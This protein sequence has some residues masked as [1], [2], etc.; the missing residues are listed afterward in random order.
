MMVRETELCVLIVRRLAQIVSLDA[1]RIDIEE[2]FDRHGL[3]SRGAI[4]LLEELEQSV[5]RSL[6]PVLI[7]RYPTPLAL[8]RHLAGGQTATQGDLSQFR[9]VFDEPIAIVGM[10][11]R[12]PYAPDLDHY[13]K[14][15][16]D[17]IDA[18]TEIPSDR[19]NADAY[20]TP[21]QGG[22]IKNVDRF[23]AGFFGISPREAAQ[24]DPQQRL[25]LELSWEALENAGLSPAL[26]R[27]SRTAVFVGAM[28][29]DYAK[30]STAADYSQHSA[31]GQDLSIIAARIS[32][33]LGLR[34]PSITLNSA[35]SSSLAAV[36]LARQSLILG[37]STLAIAGGVS[38]ML[39]PDATIAMSRFGALAPDG[40]CKAFDARADGYG[41]GEGAG[42]V[43][44]KRL[45][46]AL[47]DGDH[48]YCTIR[49]SALNNDGFSNGLSAPSPEAQEAVLRDAYASAGVDP[50]D[51]QY[52][53]THGTGTKLGDPI[54]AAALSAVLCADRPAERPLLLG[55]VKTN[56]G[57]LE[58][59]AG[60]A[61]LIKSALALENG[62][63]PPSLHFEI[64][65]P[66]IPFDGLRLKVVTALERIAERAEKPIVGVSSFGF[67]GTNCHVVLQASG[68]P[69]THFLPLAAPNSEML[70]QLATRVRDVCRDEA[71]A[72]SI[73]E[74][75]AHASRHTHQGNHRL[76]ITARTRSELAARIDD[77]LR[78]G[79]GRHPHVTFGEARSGI[80]GPVFLFGGQGSQWL[81]MGAD[82]LDEPAFRRAI[83]HCDHAMRPYL[84]R[85]LIDA[86]CSND[87]QWI[88]NTA[89]VQP[90]VV[91]VQIGLAAL[92]QAWGV[93]PSAVAGQSIGEVSAAV[94]AGCLSIEDAAGVICTWSRLVARTSGQGLMA[95]VELPLTEAQEVVARHAGKI[96]IGGELSP[97]STV[98]SG[99]AATLDKFMA[100]VEHEGVFARRI[101]IDYA[102]HSPQ[103]EPLL[104]ELFGA[105]ENIEPRM[106]SIPFYS[107]VT[108]ERFQGPLDAR[109][110]GQ[111]LRQPMQFAKA[112][113]SLVAAH[114]EIFV[115]VSPH[116]VV[117]L[118][119]TQCLADAG[120]SGIAVSSLR[121]SA[122]SRDA[123]LD[124]LR[125]LFAHGQDLNFAAVHSTSLPLV[126]AF[127]EIWSTSDTDEPLPAASSSKTPTPLVVSGKT[128]PAL[129]AQAARLRQ[130]LANHP[131]LDLGDV[132]Y[133]SATTRFPFDHRAVI[134]AADRDHAMNALIALEQGNPSPDIIEGHNRHHLHKLVFV[135]PG[136]G[137][138]WEGMARALFLSSP[139][140]RAH[141]D[142]CALALAPHV[143]FSLVDVILGVPG[144]ASL[145]RVG[146]VQP[147][148]FA[149]MVSL[150]AL[151]QSLGIVP[152][153]VVGHS[154]GE[155]AAAHVAG[156]LSLED[157]CQVIA[158][159]SQ[160]LA[161]LDGHGAMASVELPADV[162]AQ[163]IA[164]FGAKLAIAARNSPRS[165]VIAGNIDAVD[166]VV[167]E[168]AKEN[169][170]ARKIRVGYA[171]HCA[172]VESIRE[173]LLISLGKIAPQS[174]RIPFHSTV[175]GQLID[176]SELDAQY[177]YQNLR[178][179]V[180]FADVIQSLMT[181]GHLGF[182][183][184]S[185]HPVLSLPIEH[186]A[187]AGGHSVTVVGS[188]QRDE[189]ELV[190]I[191]RSLGELFTQGFSIDWGKALPPGRRIPLPAY[192]FQRERHWVPQKTP[193][194]VD[195]R[196]LGIES[197]NHPLFGAAISLAAD[198]AFVLTGCLAKH[199]HPWLL[200]HVVFDQVLLG[201]TAF[202][203]LALSAAQQV[204]LSRIED[205]TVEAPLALPTEG[206]VQL[207]IRIGSPD[208]TARRPILFF[209]RME[210]SAMNAPW[211]RHAQG[212]LTKSISNA[213]FQ[214]REWP[215]NQAQSVD[216]SEVYPR[217]AR[218]GLPY[219]ACFRG[220]RAAWRRDDEW[221]VE[222][223]LPESFVAESSEFGLHPALFDAVLHVLEID[224][225]DEHGR[226]GLPFSW[227]G[228]SL[229][230]TGAN[231]LRARLLRHPD[232]S[233][234]L[235]LADVAGEPVL[236]VDALRMR[237]ASKSIVRNASAALSD[238]L[239]RVQW[240]AA[241]RR[242]GFHVSRSYA[243]I[244]SLFQTIPAQASA[245][246]A[247]VKR[248]A[249]FAQFD[250]AVRSGETTPEVLIL[251]PD[252]SSADVI[253]SAHQS[254]HYI[255]SA[256]QTFVTDPLFV[257]AKLVLL[258]RRAVATRVEEDV[259]ALSHA[260]LWGLL[261]TA[262]SE[263]PDRAILALDIDDHDESWAALFQSIDSG[264]QQAALREGMLHV[265]RLTRPAEADALSIPAHA[266]AWRMEIPVKGSF[267]E[268][269]LVANPDVLAPLAPG[270]VRVEMRAAGLNFRDVLDSLGMLPR[271]VGPLGAE[272]AGIVTEVGSG[273]SNCV[274]GDRVMGLFLGAFGP[275]AV[276]DHRWLI[277]MPANFSFLRAASIPI[278][279]LTA[280]YGLIDL[281]RLQA[282]E[283]VLIHAAAG[284]VG[285]AAVQIARHFGAEVFGTA[286]PRK[287][288][289]LHAMGLNEAHVAS[290]RTIEFEKQFLEFTAGEGMDLVLD[291]LSREFI[292]A[293]LRLLPRGGRFI[294]MGK[295]D[296]RDPE[297]IA[298]TYPGVT[299]RVF[300][301][302]DVDPD[303][304]QHM[305]AELVALFERGALHPIPITSY[306]IRRAPEAFRFVAQARHTGKVVFTLPRTL[307]CNG[308]VLMTGGTGKLG[309]L[310]AEHLVSKYGIRHLL[311]ASRQ[312]PNAPHAEAL[313][314]K[315]ENIGARVTIAACDIADGAALQKLLASISPEH[316]LTGVVHTAGLLDDGVL[317]ALTPDRI[318]HVFSPKVDAAW[319]LH[320]QTQ[321][322][323]LPL[324]I[325]F[326][327]LSG[328]L[329]SAGQSN[330]AAANT[331]LDA[332]AFHR[333]AR[334]LA[335][336]SLSWGFWSE[337]SG[338][339]EHLGQADRARLARSGMGALS[340][341]E[342]ISLFD[343]AMNGVEPCFVPARL[344][345]PTSGK[346]GSPLLHDFVRS[347]SIR[348]ATKGIVALEQARPA[349]GRGLSVADQERV[350]AE[351]IRAEIA[352]VLGHAYAETIDAH[353]PL[354][355]LGLDSLMAVELRNRL[356]A[357]TGLRLPST[358][359]FDH[360]TPDA[361]L[362]RIGGE[363]FGRNDEPIS[364]KPMTQATIEDPIAIVAMSCRYPG[365]V[366]S[367]EDLWKLL[368]N[369][370]DAISDFPKNRG[371]NVESLYDPDP[372]VPHKTYV[373]QGG[374][375]HDADH[376]D[377]AF[378][379]I[380]PREALA[381]DPQQ[382][383]LLELSWE[384]LERAGID[385]PTLNGSSTGVFAGV[386]YND[387]G[388]RRTHAPE[389][390]EGYLGIGS[391]GSVASGRIAYTFG[392]EGPA[393]T[394]DTACSSSLVAIHLACQALRRGECSLALAGGVTVLATPTILFEF[395]RQRA[396]SPEGRS[397]AFSAAAN[398]F[399][400]AEGAGILLLAR[401]NDAQRSGYPIVGVIRGSAVNQDGKS[402]GLTAPN[403][404]AQ[405]RVVRQALDNA[406]LSPRDIGAVE[407]HGTGTELGDPIEAQA[408]MAVY[409]KGRSADEP[410]WLGSLKSNIGHAQAAAG[411][412]GI[413]KMALA[414]H[415]GILPKTL[416]ADV[417][418]RHIDWAAGQVR[419][420]NEAIPW[421]R[422]GRPRR[423]GISSF[424]ISGTNAHVILEEPPAL[425][426]RVSPETNI[427]TPLPFFLS[428]KS[429]S[430]LCSWARRLADFIVA[431]PEYSLG[432]I[433]YSLA[434]TRT[435]F[436][437]RAAIVSSNR[438]T[439]LRALDVLAQ[440][441]EASD[442]VRNDGRKKGRLVFVF[443]GQGG[444]WP[445]MARVLL[446]STPEFRMQI[447]AC[448][449]ALAPHVSFSLLDV[450]RQEKGAASLDRVDVVQP[451]L[452]AVM[453]S[454][455]AVW[456]SFGIVPDAVVG[457]SQGEIAAAYVAGGLSLE[458]ACKI[459]ALRS[460]AL[461]QLDGHGA[462]ASVELAVD[463]LEA[464]I[465]A[466]GDKLAIASLNG[467][468]SSV[469]S[470]DI[471]AVDALIAELSAG[472]I[473]AKKIRVG[474][475]SH[476]PQVEAIHTQ[477]LT[478]LADISSLKCT[479]PFYSTVTAELCEDSPFD[480]AYWY[481][482]LRQTV[483]FCET[484]QSLLANDFRFFLEISP[485]PVLS[486]A[487][488]ETAA[489][490]G[491]ES[492]IV[493]SLRR[494]EGNF[495]RL[496]L[497]FAELFIH[498]L[499][500]DLAKVLPSA[501]RVPLPT[502]PFQRSRY[503]L[504]P[505]KESLTRPEVALDSLR[506]RI[507]WQPFLGPRDADISGSWL[508]FHSGNPDE[509]T[510]AV[511]RTL[512]EQKATIEFV[513]LDE[514]DLERPHLCSRL[515]SLLNGRSWRGILSLLA[516][517]ETPL[518]RFASLPRGL[519][520]TLTL[521]QVLDD[522]GSNLPSWLFTRG[523]VSIGR[524]DVLR[525][526]AQAMVWG[527]GRVF[528]LERPKSWGG[529]LD[530]PDKLDAVDASRLAIALTSPNS[531]DQ[532]ALRGS[533]LFVRRLMRAPLDLAQM[534][535]DWKPRGTV[536]VTGGTGALGAHVARWLARSGATHLVLASRHGQEAPTAKVLRDDLASLGVRVSVLECDMSNRQSVE[537]L[538][539]TITACGDTL[540]AV[541]HTAGT[542]KLVPLAKTTL[543]DLAELISGKVSGAQHL[544]ELLQTTTL[545]AFVMFS[546]IAG[547]W[548]V[549]QEGAYAA[550][551]AYLD[552]LAERRSA[553][554]LP[555][556]S[557]AWGIWA[558]AGMGAGIGHER[559]ARHGVI[560][561]RS[562]LAMQSFEQIWRSRE[563][564]IAIAD[565]DWARFAPA[566]VAA[567]PRPLLHEIL[568]ARR[569]LETSILASSDDTF[570]AQL[571]N[572]PENERLP[573]LLA[574]V[575]GETAS[576][577]GH[578]NADNIYPRTGFFDLGLD[579]LTA[580]E[581]RRRLQ[582]VVGTN[583]PVTLAFDYPS[584]ERLASFLQNRL[585]EKTKPRE[586]ILVPVPNVD[587][588]SDDD[589]VAIVGIGLRLPGGVFDLQSL[590]EFLAQGRDAISEVPTARGY[591]LGTLY[592]PDPDASGKSYARQ[593]AFLDRI[594]LFDAEFFGITPREAIHVDPQHRL[595]LETTW[596]ALENAGLVPASLR[597]SRTGVFVG[598]ATGDYGLLQKEA[599]DVDAYVVTGSQAAF[600]AGRLAFTLGLQGPALSVDTGCSSSLVALHLA[601]RALRDRECDLALVG[602]AVVMAAAETFAILSRT[603]A[604]APDGRSKTFSAMANGFGR[605]EG[606]V[607]LTLERLGDARAK[608][609]QVLGLIRGS[610]V[611]HDGASS[612][613][614]APSGPSQEK[615]IQAA[616]DN[617]RISPTDIDV[618][619]CHGTGTALGDPIEVHA[620]AA[621]YGRGRDPKR[622]LFL[623]ALKTNIGHL[624]AASGLA[625]IAK[626][627]AS[628]RHGTV[629]PTLYCSPRNPYIDWNNLPLHVIDSLQTWPLP[630]RDSRRRAGIS[631]FGLSGTNAHVII[632]EA[633]VA[634]ERH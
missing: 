394:I 112:V 553:M 90:A 489:S 390:L 524:S 275:V 156:A 360:P 74:L 254:T 357:A 542:A 84:N 290:S 457:H 622:P 559:P 168:L 87:A 62:V 389:D 533:G 507:D 483:R 427:D 354:Q 28:W 403:G 369:G 494:E 363:L 419:L 33:T 16:R 289:T 123:L 266:A 22:F 282:G 308:T 601:C 331:F 113:Q 82:L 492:A 201:G 593:A 413:I 175:T 174:C 219:G 137:G 575:L 127:S 460:R 48:I 532:F 13:W 473:F 172:S 35:C 517:D 632:E 605:G 443:P 58:A 434:T 437:H 393:I 111:N 326:S 285:M 203:E 498:G 423:A 27:D 345:P 555:A 384:A 141:I 173:R 368:F 118:A 200:D 417:P 281:G 283:R 12:F 583:L 374:F 232:D 321:T 449:R 216:L 202:V 574:L 222:V 41:R 479:I 367:P 209:S 287:W 400:M 410:L 47:A 169:I 566:F 337:S 186:T 38:L 432:D 235:E 628:L 341:A 491:I 392:F 335:G 552:A 634:A 589:Q 547:V 402:Q 595:L 19:W 157:A 382:R 608:G 307:D 116:P 515:I 633:P 470:G 358:L 319:H 541:V 567:R 528:A 309:V 288:A 399:G 243:C 561:L 613:I 195:P 372:D 163:R 171:S 102:A 257:E 438:E 240:R 421:T 182:V 92:W 252:E 536:L 453:V 562:E 563:T 471:G 143:S 441:G 511:S 609:R 543:A 463:V 263:H 93:V 155:I 431:H 170:F 103:M 67:G 95:V 391:F 405:E 86:L 514:A 260:P 133:S 569:A 526:P 461:A 230:A 131:V 342:F 144:A 325:L 4:R 395:S 611:N 284:G 295:I 485:H 198:D 190:R 455:A 424:G 54:E 580:V 191:F 238:L 299:Y 525:C 37:E 176:G 322:L 294:E 7:W 233:V 540:R 518:P 596:Q 265:P 271:D 159:R 11:C 317:T 330:Y 259:V 44:L 65:N 409:G 158:L 59:A 448:A 49:G 621:V 88:E 465:A 617:A 502:Y 258:T 506:Y 451:V 625:G 291:C 206:A 629:A 401:L 484:T 568:E 387:Y 587:S 398:G 385:V 624:E 430:A 607:V 114:H 274:P 340:S 548:G 306:D 40:R 404:P 353:R 189:G 380:S 512:G 71:R 119:T 544:D 162:L 504:D 557:I 350:L 292:D 537:K 97:Q 302:F 217:L 313:Q 211:K 184:I 69:P 497:S 188:L 147:V 280:Y 34:G 298:Q 610:A 134:F 77:W 261:R 612:G 620:L 482:N 591:D 135:F 68:R 300:D 447:E 8:A 183:E 179:S 142:A 377:P 196:S 138:Q 529:L 223:Q 370:S 496:L 588:S 60:I 338:M 509:F 346:T 208:E 31:T 51:V 579:S 466:W 56:I 388:G 107:T 501:H 237:P 76:A 50:R 478:A 339:T 499:P 361:L 442:I 42:F 253:A 571:Q 204:G 500:V 336:T 17:G 161:Q 244:G 148:L 592:D 352:V 355:E 411:V 192:A 590:W 21:R 276:T 614:T 100:D 310:F 305:L 268:L 603:R 476:G 132:A 303:R 519:A 576:V 513:R 46:R 351:K 293:S 490:M 9:G 343:A 270:Q 386:I 239:H 615:V 495:S 55:S 520:L 344:V 454:L 130:Y 565:I 349:L 57:H 181:E 279:F 597:D 221:F 3:D 120:K 251:S 61:G 522:C 577:L 96:V 487:L 523:A 582:R 73:S 136:Q 362:R 122:P 250:A 14:V 256:L 619:E 81:H 277:R 503:W 373:S 30:L 564:T 43:I 414:M 164:R 178:Q 348:A 262:Q 25:M 315:L 269:R 630:I 371:W 241:E 585:L 435:H 510:L 272:G 231:C 72:I 210:A 79:N 199:T 376:F 197:S 245:K 66:H 450:L 378:F 185:P 85:S 425:E 468:R 459:V 598:I 160:A 121:R 554:G 359:L 538:L 516:Q 215:P 314:R 108:G 521:I 296:I 324:F 332:L 125:T 627:L 444:Q 213:Q 249:D 527:L 573:H 570:S 264:H 124:S 149:V 273:V 225:L 218:A 6:S 236:S 177:W 550:A 312:G 493:P 316:P 52:V 415:H 408:L 407:A 229:Y 365:Q 464:T 267:D 333:R 311:L 420:L 445:N 29:Q 2:R 154:Q 375:L 383:I 406:Q 146:V 328:I 205:F 1:A 323:D 508:L 115:D 139:V 109:Y 446:D 381:I 45:S 10:A 397:K 366:Q 535:Q 558:G 234:R 227:S 242:D 166:A 488:E 105:L 194:R 32:Y 304:I 24:M 456:R 228:V 549:G 15:L 18:I 145:E 151:W 212:N 626:L 214:W 180:C 481:R 152:D 334:G 600:A 505:Q 379:N 63:V 530:L 99:D 426:N 467:P 531:E 458:D 98:I 623:G 167:E 618:V 440:N 187:E 83:E 604:L 616:L 572:M 477:L 36:H 255:L 606:A 578:P 117:A 5:G 320:E 545:D 539:Q 110:W 153:A 329:G 106:G 347:T 599:R 433:A 224:S 247:H 23:D 631:A 586:S 480:A 486:Y 128:A 428:A 126:P 584:P 297:I 364:P 556:T 220:L 462:M 396:L 469:V 551:N 416:H 101:H 286:S 429:E 412:G 104:P 248:Y 418:S 602:G 472:G 422:N 207:Q 75:C 70:R 581:L 594:D 246:D 94:V 26:L 78:N 560:P 327:S 140:F 64:P 226:I 150:A 278:V 534:A 129:R 301:I 91:A 53:E 546:S 474:Y 356:S 318:S 439:L 165:S 80:H 475:A 39:T 20:P 436:E 452:F 193:P 89:L